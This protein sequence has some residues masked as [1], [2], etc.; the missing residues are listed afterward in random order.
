MGV[1]CEKREKSTEDTQ[2]ILK[3]PNFSISHSTYHFLFQTM[4]RVILDPTQ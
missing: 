3:I 2:L 1:K 4:S